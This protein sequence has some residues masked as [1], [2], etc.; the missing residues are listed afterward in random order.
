MVPVC[1][2]HFLED[3]LN[4]PGIDSSFRHQ[5]LRLIKLFWSHLAFEVPAGVLA[6]RFKRKYSIG[7]GL[8]FVALAAFL[9]PFA[10]SFFQF[11]V[12]FVLHGMGFALRSGADRALLYDEL[13][14]A[15]DP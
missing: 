7:A 1:R 11:A 9:T 12:V 15:G 2:G 6:D 5:L 14:A 4:G 13:K 10:R 8:F 3:D